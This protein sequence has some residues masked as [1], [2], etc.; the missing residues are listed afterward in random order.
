MESLHIFTAQSKD[1]QITS[2]DI[3]LFLSHNKNKQ[4]ISVIPTKYIQ[5]VE[6]GKNTMMLKEVL[7]LVKDND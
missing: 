6:E 4:L 2:K 5:R 7:I 1:K 3:E